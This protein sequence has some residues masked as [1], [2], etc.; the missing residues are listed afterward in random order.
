MLHITG[1]ITHTHKRK[2]EVAQK[3]E[4]QLRCSDLVGPGA[5]D[6]PAQPNRLGRERREEN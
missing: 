1:T 6:R 4:R 3:E 2:L 5:V